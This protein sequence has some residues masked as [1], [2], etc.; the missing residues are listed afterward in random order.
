MLLFAG[1]AFA[2]VPFCCPVVVVSEYTDCAGT[3]TVKEPPLGVMDDCR[4]NWE[5]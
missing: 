5:L 4:I 3:V 2:G 1:I